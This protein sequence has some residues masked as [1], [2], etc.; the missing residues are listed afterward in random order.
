[1]LTHQEL[2]SLLSKQ[3]GNS[4]NPTDAAD[5]AKLTA[6]FGTLPEDYEAILTYSNGISIYGKA[7]P[8]I[9]F[10]I[11]EVLAL[12]REHDLYE[13]IP[14]SLVFGSD[15][16]GTLY[17]FD[18]RPG[19]DKRVFFIREEYSRSDPDAYEQLTFQGSTLTDLIQRII[20]NQKLN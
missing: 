3:A 12:H 2:V 8:F 20:D 6:T 16:G 13:Y 4:R 10:S 15:G 14:Q 1:M 11:R 18:L 19:M 17:C 5:L 9:L 7:T